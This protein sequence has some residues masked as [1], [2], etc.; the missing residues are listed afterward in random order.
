VLPSL[1]AKNLYKIKVIIGGNA[2]TI[3]CD[4]GP[5]TYPSPSSRKISLKKTKP[6]KVSGKKIKFIPINLIA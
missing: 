5:D 1:N 4:S 3:V 2:R 6:R